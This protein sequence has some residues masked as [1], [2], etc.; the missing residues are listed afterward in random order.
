MVDYI[1][2][3]LIIRHIKYS[4]NNNKIKELNLLVIILI[5]PLLALK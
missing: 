1:F 4:K 5:M 3:N 2:S